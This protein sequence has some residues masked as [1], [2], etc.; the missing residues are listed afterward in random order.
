MK[1]FVDD[2]AGLL[3]HVKGTLISPGAARIG[4]RSW[5]RQHRS[6]TALDPSS[7]YDD[8]ESPGPHQR[9]PESVLPES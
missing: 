4:Q 5:S 1:R 9:V 7:K 8:A 3:Y 2:P 6:I